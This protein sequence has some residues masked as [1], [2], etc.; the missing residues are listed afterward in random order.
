[1][2]DPTSDYVG[3]TMKKGGSHNL[4]VIDLRFGL[5]RFINCLCDQANHLIFLT[6]SCLIC[7]MKLL[8]VPISSWCHEEGIVQ[9]LGKDLHAVSA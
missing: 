1:M 4:K 9:G 8:R 7:K 2:N 5:C 3:S 6:L